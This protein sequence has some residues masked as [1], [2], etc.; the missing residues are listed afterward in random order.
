MRHPRDAGGFDRN[1]TTASNLGGATGGPVALSLQLSQFFVGGNDPCGQNPQNLPFDSNIFDLYEPWLGLQ[2]R[3]D[4]V[5]DRESVAR[6][7]EVFVRE[8]A[9]LRAMGRRCNQ[10]LAAL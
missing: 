10:D 2:G 4:V 3:G 8:A 5:Q 7:E 6:G 1:P 9:T